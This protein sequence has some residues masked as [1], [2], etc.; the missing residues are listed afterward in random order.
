MTWVVYLTGFKKMGTK[1]WVGWTEIAFFFVAFARF[2]APKNHIAHRCPYHPWPNDPKP[3]LEFGTFSHW[4]H[5]NPIY[6][7][8]SKREQPERRA[9]AVLAFFTDHGGL[10]PPL[11]LGGSLHETTWLHPNDMDV[12]T[13]MFSFDSSDWW[14]RE[15][16]GRDRS[17][18]TKHPGSKTWLCQRWPKMNGPGRVVVEVGVS[19]W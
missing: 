17:H 4:L 15:D 1:P 11:C 18:V 12:G 16:G 13:S 14:E 2:P 7:P 5:A 10:F 6:P 8:P 9:I 19:R 3:M